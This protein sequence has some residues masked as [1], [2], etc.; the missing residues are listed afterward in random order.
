M[1]IAAREF[2]VTAF[3]LAAAGKNIVIAADWLGKWKTALQM[4]AVLF[5]ILSWPYAEVIL[6]ISV[7]LT[8][9]SGADYVLRSWRG[10]FTD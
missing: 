5:L 6:W 7:A 9:V 2:T 3:R 10:V 1:M 4:A 8:V